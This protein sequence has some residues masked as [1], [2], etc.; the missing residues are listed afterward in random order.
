LPFARHSFE[1]N[2]S[3]FTV[4]KIVRKRQPIKA[5]TEYL[6]R[7]NNLVRLGGSNFQRT[8][9]IHQVDALDEIQYYRKI[10]QYEDYNRQSIGTRYG[11]TDEE[12]SYH[13]S[14]NPNSQYTVTFLLTA[15]GVIFA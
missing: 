11:F 12:R 5:F 14:K 4:S 9:K 13:T 1:R 8:G 7:E 6:C 10:E 3:S 2:H 15:F